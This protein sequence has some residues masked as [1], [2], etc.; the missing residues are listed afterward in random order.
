MTK[1]WDKNPAPHRRLNTGER[2]EDVQAFQRGLEARSG[3][4]VPNGGIVD[5]RTKEVYR[6]VRWDLGLPEDHPMTI[7]AQLNVRRPWTRTPAA[8]A[9]AAR[10]RRED[11]LI[12]DP[13]AGAKEI[14]ETAVR[15]AERAHKELYVVSDFRPGDPKDHG[16]N[17]WD[18]AA[19]DI[20]FPGLDALVGPPHPYLDDAVVLIGHAFGRKYQKGVRIVDT[21][22]WHGWRIQ[23]IWHTPEYGGHRGHIHIGAHWIGE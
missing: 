10:R 5:E 2:G 22:Y 18:K 14:V 3:V 17:D 23:I 6:D 20:A 7:G 13:K 21:F 11:G 12:P 9:R 8:K 4:P 15:I 19:R 1:V 16:S